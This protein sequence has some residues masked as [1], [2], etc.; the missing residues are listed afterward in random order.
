MTIF[1]ITGVV[2]LLAMA[3]LG[4][5][6]WLVPGGEFR[7][8][9][10]R[11]NPELQRRLGGGCASCGRGPTEFCDEHEPGQPHGV[12][13]RHPPAPAHAAPRGATPAATD[14]Q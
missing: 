12:A 13:C 4:I 1:L 14:K 6:L 7:G 8:G 5:R 2:F 3:L 9:C 11:R 10:N